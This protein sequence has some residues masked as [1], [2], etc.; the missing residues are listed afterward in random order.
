M[1]NPALLFKVKL[2]ILPVNVDAGIV[3]AVEPPN[4]TVAEALL[5]SMFPEPRLIAPFMVKVL[6]PT[7]KVPEV[8]EVVPEMV[9]LPPSEVLPSIINSR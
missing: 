8:K 5:A 2:L 4:T 9:T 7:V 6:A 1:V 3:C